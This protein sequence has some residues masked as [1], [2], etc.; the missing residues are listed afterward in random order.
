MLTDF[1]STRSTGAN[2][3]KRNSD[4]S[5]VRTVL[6]IVVL[7]VMVSACNYADA[8]PLSVTTTATS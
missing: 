6:I 8:K 7:S 1:V 3:A 2:Q 4:R 5:V